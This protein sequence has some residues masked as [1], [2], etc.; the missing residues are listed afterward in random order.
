VI[1]GARCLQ[2][3]A[4]R[5]RHP[6]TR[7][8]QQQRAPPPPTQG[9][10]SSRPTGAG[11][12]GIDGETL[13]RTPNPQPKHPPNKQVRTHGRG[14][15]PIT[16]AD[17]KL[18][19]WRPRA[20][21]PREG[22]PR[23][24]A[25]SRSPRSGHPQP[26]IGAPPPS[27]TTYKQ[28]RVKSPPPARLPAVPPPKSACRGHK[29]PH[30][31]SAPAGRNLCTPP[32][33]GHQSR[34]NTA[35]PNNPNRSDTA[36][37]PSPLQLETPVLLYSLPP[38]PLDPRRGRARPERIAQRKPGLAPPQAALTPNTL[39]AKKKRQALK[40]HP[41]PPRRHSVTLPGFRGRAHRA[42]NQEGGPSWMPSGR[43]SFQLST[44]SKDDSLRAHQLEQ[45]TISAT[46]R[47]SGAPQA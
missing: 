20:A 19:S 46:A 38:A 36:A 18:P 40:A 17:A 16:S 3:P 30:T 39:T 21:V 5:A 28:R 2:Q 6:F 33:Q 29:A 8:Q 45:D 4:G 13:A 43:A 7:F 47:N 9:H 12:I 31:P 15:R 32:T 1:T 27:H 14:T 35:K 25:P 23:N 44:Q 11:L 37:V 24:P 10:P 26:H 22:P 41:A 34:R 42:E